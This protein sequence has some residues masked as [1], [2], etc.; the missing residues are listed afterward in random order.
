M[1]KL[2]EKEFVAI[3]KSYGFEEDR[4]YKG[5]FQHEDSPILTWYK[6]G[7]MAISWDMEYT[8]WREATDERLIAL[9]ELFKI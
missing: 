3:L 8:E 9:L 2:T 4:D 5:A 1:G 7:K 6:D